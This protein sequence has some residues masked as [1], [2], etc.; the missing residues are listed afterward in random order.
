MT[1]A[2][3]IS[4]A[5]E[6]LDDIIQRRR[7]ASD[8]LKDW[9][10]SRRFAGSKDR[11]AIASLVYDALRRR[12]SSSFAM[13]SEAPRALLLGMLA[14]LRGLGLEEIASL[15]S[16]ENHAPAPLEAE[17]VDRLVA[18]SLAGAPDWVR[19]D[20]P[21][22]LW[23]AFTVAFGADAVAEGEAL[24]GRAPIDIRA[25]RLKTTR[26]TLLAELA[27]ANPETGAWS[28][29]ALRFQPGHDGRGP[30]LQAEPAFFAGGFEIQDEGSQLVTLLAGAKPGQTVIDL[31]AGAGGKT[32]A[33]A[34]LM[35]NQGRLFATDLD[36]RRLAPLHERLARSGAG[37]AEIRIPR[38]RGHEPLADVEGQAD[39]VLV[40]APCTG[41]GTWRRNPDAKWRVRPGALAERVKDQAEVLARAA[42]LVKPGGRIA[43]ITCSVLPD[44]NDAA[45]SGFLAKHGGFAPVPL[46][47][48]L[49]S[50]EGDFSLLARFATEHGVQFS[51]R[52][53]GTD[54]FYLACVQRGA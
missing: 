10:L 50:P 32:L 14:R 11:A 15:C 24:A 36:S 51:P 28:P 17:E 7:P 44:E 35:N 43:Y 8:A 29:D 42:R 23:P 6:V 45:I 9:G 31:C 48:L 18:L 53:T 21:E 46:P 52:R 34:A 5:I 12:A 54:G 4:A 2:A 3:R 20:V 26:A 30:S 1:P 49:A 39:L 22:W 19:A 40:D 16:G 37:I 33:L 27:H 13:G 41:S 47:Q 38:S 25:N